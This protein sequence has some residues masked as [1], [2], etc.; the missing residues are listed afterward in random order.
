MVTKLLRTK[1]YIP[2]SGPV[3]VM[4]SH[5][6]QRLNDGLGCDVTLVVA[7]VGYGKT[8]LVAE[9]VRQLDRPVAWLSLDGGDNDLATFLA[10]IVAAIG[11][12][13]PAACPDLRGLLAGPQLP[14]PQQLVRVWANEIDDLP[15]QLVLVLDDYH[16]ITDPQIHRLMDELLLHPLLQLH[17]VLVTRTEPP[18]AIGRLHANRRLNELRMQDLRFLPH[19][20]A[21]LFASAGGALQGDRILEA[22]LQRTEG[23]PAGLHLAT[24]SLRSAG[25]GPAVLDKL[26]RA[27]NSFVMDYLFEQVL[28]QQPP[29]V[30]AFLIKTSILDR[31]SQ[32]LAA[33][34]AGGCRCAGG[35]GAGCPQGS[36]RGGAVPHRVG[37]RRRVVQLSC[38]VP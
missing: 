32:P 34:V 1:L 9:W 18:L 29:A 5:L 15:Q 23:W 30:H 22:L 11:T 12:V 35:R 25:D 3:A 36:G 4:R 2:R 27:S 31:L 28:V 21:A 20:A 7:P 33:A 13:F 24:L 17:L 10:Y 26:V 16:A 19:E 38:A 37:R 14:E 8:T 6:L